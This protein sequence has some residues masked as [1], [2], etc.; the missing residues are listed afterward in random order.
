MATC[1]EQLGN[2]GCVE[3]GLGQ[4]KGSAETGTPSTAVKR[5]SG[6]IRGY[7]SR[8]HKTHTTMAS[9]SCSI[10]GYLPLSQDYRTSIELRHPLRWVILKGTDFTFTVSALADPVPT[11]RREGAELLKFLFA[12]L[13]AP[14]RVFLNI[15]RHPAK[16]RD[17]ARE[18]LVVMG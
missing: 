1:G 8:V 7:G 14:G 3:T 5:V 10:K 2:T 12:D 9:Y 6:N 18:E 15:L 17:T 4:T 16:S 13:K 11:K